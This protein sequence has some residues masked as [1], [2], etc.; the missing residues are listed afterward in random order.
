MTVR[1]NTTV[2]F[3]DARYLTW[4]GFRKQAQFWVRVGRDEVLCRVSRDALVRRLGHI[5]T[6]RDLLQAARANFDEITQRC[7]ALIDASRF[8]RDG[9]VLLG[10]DDWNASAT[11]A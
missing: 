3:R 5:D 2:D 7:A 1:P 8:E 9:S 11:P 10:P 4:N 6:D